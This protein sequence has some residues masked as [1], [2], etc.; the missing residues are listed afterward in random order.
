MRNSIFIKSKKN[1]HTQKE[2]NA[3]DTIRDKCLPYVNT[4]G[5]IFIDS[6]FDVLSTVISVIDELGECLCLNQL[7][8]SLWYNGKPP[9][10]DRA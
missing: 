1:T 7:L 10:N 3:N 6:I 9:G 4:M 8:S 2:L 5:S